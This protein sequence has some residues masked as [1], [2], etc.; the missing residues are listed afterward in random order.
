MTR[1]LADEITAEHI[2]APPGEARQYRKGVF[3]PVDTDAMADAPDSAAYPARGSGPPF[4]IKDDVPRVP[5]LR[6]IL[7]PSIIALAMG[8]GA[9][10]LLL[11]PNLI[12]V[13]GYSIWWLLWLGVVTQFVVISEIERWTIATGE[14][15]FA[16]MARL[17]PGAVW[18]WF[19]LLA[20]MVS[21]FW[22]GW[23]SASSDFI[24]QIA[25]EVGGVR[26]AWQ[27][28]ALIML[29]LIW[30]GLAL[31]PIVYNSLER[32]EMSLAI[33][34]FPLLAITLLIVGIAPGDFPDLLRGA[35]S[36]GSA[37]P[38]LLTGEQFPTLL[39]A[40]GYAGSG[41]TLL[42]AQSLW[43]RDKGF[44]MGAFQGRIAGIRGENEPILDT[45]LVF[46]AETPLSVA[47]FRA[48][49]RV[50]SKELLLTFVCLILISVVM[51]T[52]LVTA[53]L[54]TGNA[55]LAGDLTGMIERQAAVLHEIG[56]S[57]LK[58]TFLLAGALVLFSTQVGIVD[59]VTRIAG[60]IFH[61]R[62]GFRSEHWNLRRTFLVFLTIFVLASAAIIV[63][64][65][66]DRTSVNQLRPN[67]LVLIAGPFVIASMYAFTLVVGTINTRRLPLALRPSAW[68]RA[69]L[70]WAATLWGWFT[71]EQISRVLLDLANSPEAADSIEFHPVRAAVYAAWLGSLLWF[72][73][74]LLGPGARRPQHGV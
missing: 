42:L 38:A 60:T 34:F 39:I 7:G 18:P 12:T 48:W 65:W 56:G 24:A 1:R 10:E 21:F 51:T 63:V 19:F 40:V 25:E 54:G 52:L 37:P 31:S 17:G 13:N 53:T 45:G 43:L 68:R 46:S 35:V 8:L 61:E 5:G 36:V 74:T 4:K 23:A 66:L 71:A 62:Y 6:N 3:V 27:P 29:L 49:M 69:G 67:F 47:R 32:L 22:P 70:V 58:I 33:G 15:V 55:E 30:L 41:G 57:P 59:T 64:S 9:G 11:W 72:G 14:S 44:G 2:D 20:T 73:W 26:I 50:A 28:I 16:G